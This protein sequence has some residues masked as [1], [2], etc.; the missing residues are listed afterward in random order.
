MLQPMRISIGGYQIK[1][2][3]VYIFV[4][5]HLQRG[6]LPPIEYI[7]AEKRAEEMVKMFSEDLKIEIEKIKVC[8][9]LSKT[10]MLSLIDTLDK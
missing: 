6:D 2:A 7:N 1:D 5:T 3:S 10:E 9:N 8:K 4:F